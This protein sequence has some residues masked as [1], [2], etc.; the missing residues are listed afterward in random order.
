MRL[1][2][3]KFKNYR[4]FDGWTEIELAPIT[5]LYGWNSAGKSSILRLLVWLAQSFEKITPSPLA[6]GSRSIFKEQQFSDIVHFGNI[7]ATLEIELTFESE[8]KT[9]VLSAGCWY[10]PETGQIVLREGAFKERGQVIYQLKYLADSPNGE[11]KHEIT[12]AG[13]TI[14]VQTDWRGFFPSELFT[15]TSGINVSSSHLQLMYDI[16]GCINKVNYLGPHRADIGVNIS[17]PNN[18]TLTRVGHEEDEFKGSN[19]AQILYLED[20]R[21]NGKFPQ[22]RE[23]FERIFSDRLLSVYTEASIFNVHLRPSSKSQGVKL[24]N[25]GEGMIQALPF[26]VMTHLNGPHRGSIDIVEQPELH[27][28][29][30]AHG[31]VMDTFIEAVPRQQSTYLVETHSENILF[32]LRTRIAEE[33]I[34]AAQVVGYWVK[35]G[36]DG[37]S[38][39]T[40][41]NFQ[42][43]GETDWWPEGVFSEDYDEVV[44]LRQAQNLRAQKG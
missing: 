9:L 23:S 35:Q 32:R 40:K 13:H 36:P 12:Y 3:L 24:A 31:A 4:A 28:H 1:A 25:V 7:G 17:I 27:L 38:V 42:E 43:D 15:T 6:M 39:V 41:I 34:S 20:K 29:P 30:E 11:P 37:D 18:S 2:R 33:K 8:G 22:I 19:V 16:A 5:V 44:K 10:I 26:V 21:P 14:T